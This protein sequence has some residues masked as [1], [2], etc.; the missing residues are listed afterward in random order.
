MSRTSSER[1]MYVQFTPSV[2]CAGVSLSSRETGTLHEKCPNTGFF[3]SV[4]SRIWTEYEDLL[5]KSPYSVQM[6]ENTDQKKLRTWAI[7]TQRDVMAKRNPLF[8][9]SVFCKGN[10]TDIFLVSY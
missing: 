2:Q 3:W 8:L 10:F 1:L 5:H 9:F 7:F 6:R 4:F